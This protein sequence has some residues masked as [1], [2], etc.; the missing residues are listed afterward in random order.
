MILA[1]LA[2]LFFLSLNEKCNNVLLLKMRHILF[3]TVK[4]N[5]NE[6]LFLKFPVLMYLLRSS[7]LM[8]IYILSFI[9]YMTKYVFLYIFCTNLIY[10]VLL[11][12]YFIYLKDTEKWDK[13]R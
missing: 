2:P 7:V 12:F 6:M 4:L 8:I 11:N 10:Y 9:F 1:R 3:G 13:D 5:E